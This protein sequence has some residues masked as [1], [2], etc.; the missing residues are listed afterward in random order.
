MARQPLPKTVLAV[1]LFGSSA[2]LVAAGLSFLTTNAAAP[3]AGAAASPVALPAVP[4]PEAVLPIGT[5]AFTRPM[6]HRDRAPGPDKA[7]AIAPDAS[8]PTPADSAT[9]DATDGSGVS[10]RGIIVS[11]R[12]PRAA[13]QS[14]RTGT[15]TWVRVGDTVDSWKVETISA[16]TVRIRKDDEVVELKIREDK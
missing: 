6:F 13:L 4:S 16:T 12:G 15:L 14:S 1:I 5:D 8:G 3:R 7:P 2:A 11:D 10:I 9:D